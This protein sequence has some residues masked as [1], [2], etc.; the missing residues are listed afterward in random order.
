MNTIKNSKV[1]FIAVPLVVL[2]IFAVPMLITENANAISFDTLNARFVSYENVPTTLC[3]DEVHLVTMTLQ[4]TGTET[5]TSAKNIRLGSQNPENNNNWGWTRVDLE[6]HVVAP[7]QHLVLTFY[8]RAPLTAG[9]YNFQWGMLQENVTWFGDYTAN[10]PIQ[11]KNCGTPTPTPTPTPT[12]SPTELKCPISNA[13]NRTIFT[14]PERNSEYIRAN[15]TQ[16]EATFGPDSFNLASG[17]YK[18]TLVSFDWHSIY[19]G[20]NQSNEQ[21]KVILKNGG[22]TVAT[23]N[24]SADIPESQDWQ[25]TV[26]NTALALTGAANSITAIHAFYPTSNANSLIPICAAFDLVQQQP[27]LPT[28]NIKANGSDGP[29]TI[30]YN[31]STTLS[32]TSKNATSC[33]AS[34]GWSGTKATSGSESTGN[35]TSNHTYTI[36]CSNANGSDTD[37][38]T[39]K[40]RQQEVLPT[41]DIKANGSDGPITVDYNTSANLSWTSSNATSCVASDDWSGSKATS[42][43]ESTGN[44][45]SNKTFTITCN[46]QF[47]SDTDSVT[48]KVRQ[49]TLPTVDIKANGSNGPITINYNTSATLSW[50]STNADSC[51]AS[52]G[53]SGNKSTSGSEST[54]NLTSNKTYTI[55]CSNQYGSDSDSVTVNVSQAVL[56][57]VDIKANSSDGP[58][59]I[60]Y[61]TSATLGWTSTNADS[62][63]ASNGWSGNKSTSGSESTGN[64]TSNHVYTITCSNTNGSASD[65]V[66]VNVQNQVIPTVNLLANGSHGSITI[67]YNT[68]ANLSWDSTNANYCIASNDWSGSKSTNGSESTGNLTNTR[69]YTITCYNNNGS[70]SD[71]VTVYV[72]NQNNYP[73]VDLLANGSHGSI[74]I[75]NNTSTT[76]S[77]SSSNANTCYAFNGWT[78]TKST[79]GSESTGNL[80]YS[81]T[82]TISCSNSYGSASD[83]VTVNVG[84]PT[85]QDM[86]SLQKFGS[87]I[88][89]G[90]SGDYSTITVY[91]NDT[92]RFAIHV[93]SLTSN[94]L[95]NVRISDALPAGFTYVN[96]STTLDGILV[97]D[98][99][100][101]TGINIGT[102]TPNQER[103]VRFDARAASGSGLTAGTSYVSNIAY[104]D[105]DSMNRVT[106]Q[107]S[108]TIVNSTVPN[109]PTG[110][111]GTVA[112]ALALGALVTLM[113]MGYT[114]T[115]AF[116]KRDAQSI[117][118]KNRN[119]KNKF[120]FA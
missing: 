70:A 32:W 48:V 97:S 26:T 17:I 2:A 61:N 34:N 66:T 115:G 45:T 85:G 22:A 53:W 7:S 107:L 105:A 68:S 67:N 92:V 14:F 11:V 18:V 63:V 20:Q 110:T 116:K 77:W 24:A 19:G 79:Y 43:S 33:V 83:S 28:V 27:V 74:T 36:T 114:R 31:T 90:Q 54:G 69:T 21:Y 75:P 56:P 6:E 57:T 12:S 113:Y 102:L 93:T 118:R 30:D 99:I 104:A 100:T 81:K 98:G 76:L 23:S 42:G 60:N 8:I 9:T 51:V 47:G 50:N 15:R 55:T 40:V 1:W 109:V 46:N 103:I 88:T 78:G 10:M 13:A 89:R 87:N 39:V 16:E 84:N 3:T 91:P 52:N 112:M 117:A 4:N 94:T 62:C 64:L 95:Y 106:T 72:N 101:N 86:V 111:T 96:S 108:I 58:I 5:W 37:S 29:I 49:A 73:T 80:T 38:V 44:L 65:S 59:T 71:S 82:Y 25:T 119:D 41:V 35:L 120:N